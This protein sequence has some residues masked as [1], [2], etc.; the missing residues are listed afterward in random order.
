MIDMAWRS[1]VKVK[2]PSD[3]PPLFHPIM[4]DNII[5]V[6]EEPDEPIVTRYGL[7]LPLIIRFPNSDD[8]FTWL[9]PWRDEVGETSLLY[10]LKQIAD[11]H[12]GLKGLTL[13]V[14][15]SGFGNARRY[16]V[17]VIKS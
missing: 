16:K 10:Q 5:R 4:G 9:I 13:K 15:V 7:R 12:N 8:K 11:E 1:R 17:E 3:R 14:S 6:V 2:N